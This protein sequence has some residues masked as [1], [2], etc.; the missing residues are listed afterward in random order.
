M[1]EQLLCGEALTSRAVPGLHPCDLNC[2]PGAL[3]S[4]PQ[5]RPARCPGISVRFHMCLTSHDSIAAFPR[6]ASGLAEIN[7][8]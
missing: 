1:G 8:I 3:C 6:H 4:R 2:C 5:A 7:H